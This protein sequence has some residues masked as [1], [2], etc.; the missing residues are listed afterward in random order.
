MPYEVDF[1]LSDFQRLRLKVVPSHLAQQPSCYTD[2]LKLIY[3]LYVYE[4]TV[5][6]CE[7]LCGCWELNSGPLEEQ[8]V[9]LTAESSLQPV[10]VH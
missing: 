5:A 2:F 7:L 9:F 6:S 8:S 3:L 1:T 10:I 4:D